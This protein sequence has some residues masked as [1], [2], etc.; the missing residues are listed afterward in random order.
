MYVPYGSAAHSWANMSKFNP[1][2]SSVTINVICMTVDGFDSNGVT[3]SNPTSSATTA[4]IIVAYFNAADYS[5]ESAVLASDVAVAAK[6]TVTADAPAKSGCYRI[7]Y[8]WDSNDNIT[9]IC[10]YL[11]SDD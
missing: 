3:I 5:F 9:P 11:Q 2:S 10:E 6:S 4:D 1:A 7:A 8:V